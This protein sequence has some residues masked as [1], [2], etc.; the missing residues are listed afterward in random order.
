MTGRIAVRLHKPTWRE[1]GGRRPGGLVGGAPWRAGALPEPV[2]MQGALTHPLPSILAKLYVP[3]TAHLPGHAFRVPLCGVHQ[4]TLG[5]QFV[6][7]MQDRPELLLESS[8][9]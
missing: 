8:N 7:T 5:M 9:R 3:E 4:E 1:G 6:G 2:R